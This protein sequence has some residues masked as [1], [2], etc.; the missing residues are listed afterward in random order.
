M[1]A[2][3]SI[4]DI[5]PILF[6]VLA[7]GMTDADNKDLTAVLRLLREAR[8]KSLEIVLVLAWELLKGQECD[9]A[10]H[11]L[12][13][14]DYQHPG[15]ARIKA[16]LASVLF[17]T[18]VSVWKSYV[19]EVRSLPHDEEAATIVAAIESA[20]EQ[21][22]PGAVALVGFQRQKEVAEIARKQNPQYA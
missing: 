20:D 13:A 19:T 2:V 16:T 18:D 14:A 8:P 21:Q 7:L 15:N 4:E 6:D 10:R 1:T 17:F 9:E 3:L 12:E 11:L 22:L 5:A